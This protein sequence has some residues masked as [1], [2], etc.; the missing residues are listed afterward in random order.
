MDATVALEQSDILTM[1]ID[2]AAWAETSSLC[3]CLIRVQPRL[4]DSLSEPKHRQEA[5]KGTDTQINQ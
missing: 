3:N 1:R 4:R 5:S 2:F